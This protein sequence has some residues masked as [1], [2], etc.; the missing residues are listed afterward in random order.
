M[1]H[2]RFAYGSGQGQTF[3]SSLHRKALSLCSLK[4]FLIW[5]HFKNKSSIPI[6]IFISASDFPSD[7]MMYHR[8]LRD[9]AYVVHCPLL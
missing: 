8:C 9:L 7:A 1:L 2:L 4:M 5:H 6:R 3:K